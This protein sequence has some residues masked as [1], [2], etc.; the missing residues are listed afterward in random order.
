[1]S[2]QGEMHDDDMVGLT[3]LSSED[4]KVEE[5]TSKA[6]AFPQHNC[7]CGYCTQAGQPTRI[8]YA[9]HKVFREK[10]PMCLDCYNRIHSEK[11]TIKQFM[12]KSADEHAQTMRG[13]D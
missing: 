12:K 6:E 2:S 7:I 3:V 10:K 1:M 4:N 9:N 13:L 8:K 5:C 11:L